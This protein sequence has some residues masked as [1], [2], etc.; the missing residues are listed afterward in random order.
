MKKIY[1]LLL[2]L[3]FIAAFTGCSDLDEIIFDHEKQVFPTRENAILLEVIMPTGSLVDDEY[4]I[5]GDF[6]GGEEAF[7]NLEWKL[8][9]AE[10]NLKWGIYLTPSSF[11]N[12]KTLAD[13]FYFHAKRQGEE[14]SVRNEPVVHTLDVQVGGFTNV[15]VDRWESYFGDVV[16]DTYSIY[17]NDQTGWEEIALYA[18]GEDGDVTPGWPGLLPTDTEVIN[19]VTYT[20]FEMGEELK[21]VTMNLIFNNN[22]NGKQID[23]MQGFI[24]NRDVYLILTGSSYEEVD[25]DVIP[26]EGYTIYVDDQTGWEELALYTW[27]DAEV[28]GWPGIQPTGTKEINDVTFT[29]FE[30]GEDLNGSSLNVIFN[31]NGNDIQLGDVPV[32]LDKDYYFQITPDGATEINPEGEPIEEEGYLIFVENNTGWDAI[33]LHYWGEGVTGTDWPGIAP[34]G[35]EEVNEVSYL[36]FELP[37]EL[38]GLHINTIFNNNNE[39]SQF[40]GPYI[41]I[42][43]D[44]YFNVTSEGFTEIE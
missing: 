19:G 24:L 11:Q 32:V 16:K 23:A 42:E 39:G 2:L 6:N 30:M 36:Y 31:N 29:Y 44:Y 28:A 43:K 10:N 41:L 9:K 14:R 35:T 4:Y 13:G 1:Y 5:I 37:A 27:G 33:A 34:A 12:G 40:D 22:N 18:Y 17:V 21:D 26:Y 15:W 8:E 25:P 7:G 3:P 38:N 20:V